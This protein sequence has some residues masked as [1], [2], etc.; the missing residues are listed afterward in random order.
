M[1]EVSG[2]EKHFDRPF[3]NGGFVRRRE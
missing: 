2:N 1:K 3:N